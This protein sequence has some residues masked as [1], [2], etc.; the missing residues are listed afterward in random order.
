VQLVS[1]K[2]STLAAAQFTASGAQLQSLHVWIGTDTPL[3]PTNACVGKEL[4]QLGRIADVP[5]NRAIGPVQPAGGL[6]HAYPAVVVQSESPQSAS[7]SP[8]L[9]VPSLQLVSP[10]GFPPPP[11][12]ELEEEALLPLPLFDPE[13]EPT[14]VVEPPPPPEP[15]LGPGSKTLKSWT[16][17]M[18]SSAPQAASK[19][20]KIDE[21]SI[22]YLHVRPPVGLRRRTMMRGGYHEGGRRPNPATSSRLVQSPAVRRLRRS[23]E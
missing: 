8:S 13:L 2:N 18:G 19:P 16:H 4:G 14:L 6:T 10:V 20:R 21:R 1:L 9:S 7:L 22:R 3:R 17:A 11:P 5:S 23:H 12:A 15:L